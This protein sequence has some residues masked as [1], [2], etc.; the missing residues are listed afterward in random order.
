MKKVL[1][2]ARERECTYCKSR[3]ALEELFK[4]KVSSRDDEVDPEAELDWF[5]LTVGF[6]LADGKEPHDAREFALHIRYHTNLG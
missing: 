2:N 6:A 3:C 5:S 4:E 1:Q